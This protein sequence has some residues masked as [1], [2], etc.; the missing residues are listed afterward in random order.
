MD[1]FLLYVFVEYFKF[2]VIMSAAFSFLFAVVNNFLLNKFWTF[3][4]PSKNY[5]KLFIKF[6]LVSLVGF[7]LTLSL[8]Y[9]FVNIL[10]IWYMFAKALTSLVVLSWNFLGNKF[11]TFKLKINEPS[12]ETHF[13]FDLSIV[14][15]AYNEE[16][17]I[18]ATL[19][20]INDFLAT[21]S[22]KT[23]IVVVDDGS[24]D[25]TKEIVESYKAKIKGLKLCSYK[26]NVGKGF[27]V[28]TGVEIAQGKYILVTD[29]DNSTPIAEVDKL[30]KAIE[31]KTAKIAIG[32]RYLS[33]SNVQIRQPKYRI[34]LGRIGNFLIRLFLIDGIKDTQ[35]GFKLFEH[36]TAKNI[37]SLQKVKRFGF[38]MEMLVVANSLDYKI[39]EV[40]VDWFNSTESR[41]R[42]I[43]DALITLKD[44][45]YI[46]I[47]LWSGRYYFLQIEEK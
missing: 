22:W 43:K 27:A 31:E 44:L 32:S 30:F 28:K 2:P 39:V 38:D 9:L 21:K 7:L 46:K 26:P 24:S 6:L 35:C 45:F 41:V 14:V 13:R 29:A 12:E 5:R 47:N 3:R 17:R 33:A 8:M 1:L 15:P 37:F 19:L 11:W 40:P 25:K 4:D 20:I 16:N 10:E 18:G 23:E 42:P 36:N 34:A